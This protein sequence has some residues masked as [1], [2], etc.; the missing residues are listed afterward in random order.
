[1]LFYIFFPWNK[2]KCTCSPR[3][4][5][6]FVLI[7]S[8]L[9]IIFSAHARISIYVGAYGQTISR[10]FVFYAIFLI[11]AVFLILLYKLYKPQKQFFPRLLGIVLVSFSILSYRNIDKYI[12]QHN[13]N[14]NIMAKEM[15]RN[16]IKGNSDTTKLAFKVSRTLDWSYLLQLSHDAATEQFMMLKKFPKE[17][18]KLKYRY[19]KL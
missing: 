14:H 6:L 5:S 18:E 4:I 2:K 13:I 3:V 10:I 17:S 7:L 11:G 8:T 12:I 1:M 9:G 19:L 16:M 15:Q